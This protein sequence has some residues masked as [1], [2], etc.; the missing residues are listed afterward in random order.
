M[1]D[2]ELGLL[3]GE[4][5]YLLRQLT[6][7]TKRGLL[8]WE[9]AQYHPIQLS[10]EDDD[11]PA[12]FFL[13]HSFDVTASYGQRTYYAEVYESLR[14]LSG[15]SFIMMQLDFDDGQGRR[16]ANAVDDPNVLC[17]FPSA[18][19]FAFASAVLPQIKDSAAVEIG[20]ADEAFRYD[21][22]PQP[23][24]IREHPLTK[25]GM[26][27]RSDRRI[28][29]FHSAVKDERAR[30]KLLMVLEPAL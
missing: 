13:S 30:K 9:C 15:V 25:L 28:C 14:I 29:D 11:E 2:T 23:D 8:S 27:L 12:S 3:H 10:A 20:G 26:T 7:L 5:N 21:D 4:S 17:L 24:C 18:D 6:E 19:M 1:T 16:K 22:D